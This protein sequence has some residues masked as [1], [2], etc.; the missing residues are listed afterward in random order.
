MKSRA[1]AAMPLSLRRAVKKLGGDIALAR[2]ARALTMG[3]MADRAS[4]A[5]STYQRI[6]KGDPA[7]AFG[8]YAMVLFSLGVGDRIRGL[9]D[10]STDDVGL[11]LG[12]DHLPKRVTRPKQDEAL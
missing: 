9:L 3:M 11:L 7:V 4:I 2:R 12:R 5:L 10:Q 1:M 6:E 8:L